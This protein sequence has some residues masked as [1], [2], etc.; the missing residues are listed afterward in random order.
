MLIEVV[1]RNS[2]IISHTTC[3]SSAQNVKWFDECHKSYY[4]N[5]DT[6]SFIA[7]AVITNLLRCTWPNVGPMF[8][9][10]HQTMGW[11]R[12]YSNIPISELSLY[13]K[14]NMRKFY[15]VLRIYRVILFYYIPWIYLPTWARQLGTDDYWSIYPMWLWDYK[16]AHG[17]GNTG[18][19]LFVSHINY[20]KIFHKY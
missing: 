18:T 11:A 20:K 13:V 14:T 15:S 19:R 5:S 1:Y 12:Y 7:V 9:H 2:N 3:I 16:V 8:K 6:K 4:Y 10:A 17:P